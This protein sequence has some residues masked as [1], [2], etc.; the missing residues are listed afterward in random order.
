ML[1]ITLAMH[2]VHASSLQLGSEE[3][4]SK[5]ACQKSR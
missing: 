2:S 5:N 4:R 3:N 1:Y